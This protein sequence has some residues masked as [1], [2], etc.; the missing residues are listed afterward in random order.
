[1]LCVTLDVCAAGVEQPEVAVLGGFTQW[2]ATTGCRV[3]SR[4]GPRCLWHEEDP[5]AVLRGGT[6]VLANPAGPSS[7]HSPLGPAYAH[8]AFGL[9]CAPHLSLPPGAQLE[10]WS[11]L[12]HL[13]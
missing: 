11:I 7:P 13:G 9:L 8:L 12:D 3:G 2:A 4:A 1:M 6:S 10:F 5:P